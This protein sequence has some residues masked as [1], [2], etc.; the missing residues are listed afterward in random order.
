[1]TLQEISLLWHAMQHL[2]WLIW[3]LTQCFNIHYCAFSNNYEFYYRRNTSF[4]PK[5]ST[6]TFLYPLGTNNSYH[7]PHLSKLYS[8]LKVQL[9]QKF[10]NNTYTCKCLTNQKAL[11]HYAK[12]HLPRGQP[13][14]I[15]GT[16]ARAFFLFCKM[17]S[18]LSNSLGLW[19][20]LIKLFWDPDSCPSKA[21]LWGN[22]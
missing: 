18:I 20:Q 7:L 11:S 2:Q 22:W 13:M 1:M 16:T 6:F 4:L 9:W 3:P 19:K 8:S 5:N 17:R 12:W 14:S 15:P 21:R 10:F